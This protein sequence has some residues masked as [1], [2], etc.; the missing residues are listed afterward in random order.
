MGG[1]VSSFIDGYVWERQARAIDKLTRLNQSETALY[2]SQT[3]LVEQASK[4]EEALFQWQE[5]RE[6]LAHGLQVR[7]VE[8]AEV[9]RQAQHTYETNEMRRRVELKYL[10]AELTHAQTNLTHARTTL[11]DAEQQLKAQSDLGEITY[12]ITHKRKHYELLDLEMDAAEKQAVLKK[13]YNGTS[14]EEPDN[15][16]IDDALIARRDQLNASGLD[17]SKIDATLKQRKQR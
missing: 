16:E 11:V 14:E 9:L 5:N 3:Q 6:K 10:N 2:G 15:D 8:R 7:R 12:R 17:T 4:R 1:P 13:H